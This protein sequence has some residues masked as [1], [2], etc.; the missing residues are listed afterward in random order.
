MRVEHILASRPAFE[1]VEDTILGRIAADCQTF[2]HESQ[3]LPVFK[4]LPNTYADVQKVKVRKHKTSSKFV[5]TFNEAF[6]DVKDLRQRAVFTESTQSAAIEGKDL[7]YVLP[8]DGYKFMYCT[9]VKHSQADYQ[10]V[11]ESIFQQFEGEKAEQLIHDLLKFSYVRENLH[12][13]IKEQ[14]EIIFYNVPYYYA[15]RV[16]VTDYADLLTQVTR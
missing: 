16:S 5:E 4:F 1:L 11:F 15:A 14:A 3:G 2:I 13:G 12:E 10:Q 6:Q 8:R 9:E 7:F